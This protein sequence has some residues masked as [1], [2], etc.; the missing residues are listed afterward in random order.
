MATIR[1]VTQYLESF[2]PR[3][4][5]ESW[6]NSG[7]NVGNPDNEV[8]G[9]LLALDFTQ[10]VIDEAINIGANLIITHHPILFKQLIRNLTGASNLEQVI[11]KA[12]KNDIALYSMHTNLD[13]WI[14]GINRR[15]AGLLGLENLKIFDNL[16]GKL[17]KLVTFV[18]KDYV[19]QV[20]EAIFSA[21]AGVIGNYDWCS[22]N[23]EG[24]GTFR[25][26]PGTNPFVGEIGKVHQEPEVRIE[27]IFPE[28]LTGR[29]IQA[30]ISSHPYEEVAYD[31]YP[32]DNDFPIAG[33]GLSGEFSEPIDEREFLEL[34]AKKLDT[35]VLKHSRFLGKKIKKLV[36]C[37]G[38]CGF[39]LD[40][41]IASG[42]DAFLLG[43]TDYHKF[44]AAQDKILLVEAGHYETEKF[45][46]DIF[47]DL[48][49]KKFNTFAIRKVS[50]NYNFVN[51]F[52]N[53]DY[54]V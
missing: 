7:L 29:V 12:I 10:D 24:Y 35:P 37:T 30:L 42:A 52:I 27:T 5:Q 25:A 49:R 8:R 22:F 36:I 26:Q 47:Y 3:S 43:D 51:Y 33:M 1:E 50:K 28:H 54:T 45:A 32:L 6:D 38:G 14:Y 16:Q 23:T 44:F 9:I 17:K 40:K 11:I 41:V 18:P 53:K 34:V 4:W 13:S 21:G 46:I 31:I 20:R 39:L 2:A 48:L 19:Q 15:I